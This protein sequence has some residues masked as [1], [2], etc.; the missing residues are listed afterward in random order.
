[1]PAATP[2]PSRAPP[3]SGESGSFQPFGE[4]G[5]T[6]ADFIDIINPLQHIPIVATIYRAMTGDDIDPGARV[7]GGALF[8]GPIGAVAATANAFLDETTGKDVGEHVLAFL[9]GEDTGD[10]PIAVASAESRQ[11]VVPDLGALAPL[12]MTQPTPVPETFA[13]IELSALAP[14][15]MAQPAPV[16]ETPAPIELSALSALAPL[17]TVGPSLAVMELGALPKLEDAPDEIKTERAVQP[18]G[19]VAPA[20]G[21][22]S[23]TMLSALHKYEASAL[24]T[25]ATGTQPAPSVTY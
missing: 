8:G 16:Q 7:A 18:G 24:L 13:P 11:A 10:A 25:Q 17:S 23:E 21:W 14:L 15:S 5:F 19:A 4:D 22:F 6:F 9:G 12:P 1:M 3:T 2:T 20:G